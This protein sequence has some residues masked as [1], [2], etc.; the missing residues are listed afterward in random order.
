MNNIVI[1]SG[2]TGSKALQESIDTNFPGLFDTNI[3]I[4]A[5]DNGK[6][7]G[8]CRKILDGQILGPS[9]L[10]KNQLEKLKLKISHD[11]E[12]YKFEEKLLNWL[13]VRFN[14]K[15]AED[16]A[17][18]CLHGLS[19]LMSEYK[20]KSE[21]NICFRNSICHFF[22][23]NYLWTDSIK[24]VGHY[25]FRPYLSNFSFTDF[26]ISNIIYAGLASHLDN[27]LEHAGIV[28][29]QFLGI[30]GGVYLVSDANLYLNAITESGHII[31]DEGDIVEWKN[32]DDKIIDIK[33]VDNKGNVVVPSVGMNP[34]CSENPEY[35][36]G[37]ARII[38]AA[39]IIIFSSGTQWSSLI[40][41]Y[42]HKGL[43]EM[44]KNSK[45]KKFLIMNN[46]EDKDMFNVDCNELLFTVSRYLDLRDTTVIFNSNSDPYMHCTRLTTEVGKLIGDYAEYKL[47]DA[48]GMKVH[49]KNVFL[50]VLEQYYKNE[51]LGIN[52][53]FTDFDDTIFPRSSELKPISYGIKNIKYIYEINKLAED[54]KDL[55]FKKTINVISG[56]SLHRFANVQKNYFNNRYE[57]QLFTAFPAIYC[58]GGNSVYIK[59]D[60]TDNL[61]L[62]RILMLSCILNNDYFNVVQ[63]AIQ[64]V[65]SHV[66]DNMEKLNM[67]M[68]ENRGGSIISIKPI[69]KDRYA[70]LDLLNN[71][72][73]DLYLKNKISMKLKAYA[74]GKT[75]IDIMSVNYNKA[76]AVKAIMRN[77]G[78]SKE[79]LPH[80]LYIG[81][82]LDNGNDQSIKT[83]GCKVLKVNNVQDTYIF[84]TI[85]T[86]YFKHI[87]RLDK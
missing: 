70:I 84:L 63:Y 9:D 24:D 20:D 2:G 58:D 40:P 15:D 66:T 14:A 41:T 47:S 3:I 64:Y 72:L 17:I 60:A 44:I 74:T 57:A 21:M 6:S 68:F 30:D 27:S 33:L 80:C 76:A 82:E 56:N 4:S 19:E 5:Y 43:N 49:N 37:I 31:S 1:F 18:I 8:E 65:N 59:R 87:N 23:Q 73:D 46:T 79:D 11:P 22:F 83:L 16:A 45:A 85:L 32:S 51:L 50:A 25:E 38:D 55:K 78:L 53:I 86:Y 28:M 54:D 13:E 71:M 69:K 26:S 42:C 48:K 34:D 75:T 10:R 81:D 7:T 36:E 67:S 52:S 77:N 29:A 62:D 12:T 39:D 35:K 61:V